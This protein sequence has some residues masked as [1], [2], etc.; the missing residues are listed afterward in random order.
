MNRSSTAVHRR[1]LTYQQQPKKNSQWAN[2]EF[3]EVRAVASTANCHF[4]KLFLFEA[5]LYDVFGISI[6]SEKP[7]WSFV[8]LQVSD[9]ARRGF[10]KSRH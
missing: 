7:T 6:V 2:Y 9:A 10:M 3:A 8:F 5:L 4:R 1:L